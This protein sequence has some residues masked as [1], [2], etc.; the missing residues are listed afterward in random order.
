MSA[1]WGSV[2]LVGAGPGAA[3]LLTLRGLA[4]LRAADVVVH[5]RLVSRAVLDLAPRSA[6]RI[7][8]GK[9]PGD[10]SPGRFTQ[11]AISA[12]LQNKVLL[13]L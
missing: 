6:E 4:R 12:L 8:V 11:A 9:V 3:D 7:D 5:D 1:W 10:R 2:H 13:G